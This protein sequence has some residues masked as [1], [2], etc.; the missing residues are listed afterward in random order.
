[1]RVEKDFEDLL[2]LFNKNGVKYCILGAFA[3]AFHAR[4]RYTKD[5]DILVESTSENGRKIVSSLEEFGFGSLNITEKDFAQKGKFVQ[6]GFEPVR[7]DLITSI[8]GLTFEK[9]WKNRVQGIY[10]QVKV[11]FMGL[12]ELVESKK[13]AARKQDL[14]DLEILSTVAPTSFPKGVGRKKRRS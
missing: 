4:P 8:R 12:N 7:V 5:L 6:L 9:I 13:I 14:A 2:E 1:M 11:N 10:G 3:F